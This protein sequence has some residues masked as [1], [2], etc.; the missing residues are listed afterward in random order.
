MHLKL[1]NIKS[2]NEYI[3]VLF[4]INSQLKLY[5][6]NV[7]KEDKLKNENLQY[8]SCLECAPTVAISRAKVQ[9]IL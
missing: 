4:K 5:E 8:I 3:S 2:I 9:K 6:E 1:Q 7:T